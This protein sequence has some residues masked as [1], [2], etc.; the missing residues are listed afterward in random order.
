VIFA[1]DAEATIM[2][3]KI[4]TLLEIA[5][6]QRALERLPNVAQSNQTAPDRKGPS[7]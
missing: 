6:P 3:E 5:P 1:T 2:V 7:P 4:F